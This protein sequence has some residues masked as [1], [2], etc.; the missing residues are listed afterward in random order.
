MV[1]K[2]TVVNEDIEEKILTYSRGRVNSYK[3]LSAIKNGDIWLVRI[4]AEIEKEI[5]I[6]SINNYSTTQVPIDGLNLAAT[7]ATDSDNETNKILMLKDFLDDF[8][9]EDLFK[10]TLKPS[11]ENGQLFVYTTLELDLPIYNNLILTKLNNILK[12]ISIASESQYLE[13]DETECNKS[14]M[15]TPY[16]F[17]GENISLDCYKFCNGRNNLA[18]NLG[19]KYNVVTIYESDKFFAYKVRENLIKLFL[20]KYKFYTYTSNPFSNLIIIIEALNGNE[21]I[22][23]TTYSE[24]IYALLGSAGE[25]VIDIM[26]GFYI[27]LNIIF[28]RITLHKIPFDIDS[29]TLAKVTSLKASLTFKRR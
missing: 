14:L 1:S 2:T 3:E 12:Q 25:H 22:A 17:Y 11:I 9:F 23:S 5:L 15:N 8:K 10:I 13:Q 26:P 16:S 19:S 4:E 6:E 24:E 27:G 7:M 18:S 21:V 20:D 28:R 29:N